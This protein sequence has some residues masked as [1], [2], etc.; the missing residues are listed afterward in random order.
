MCLCVC[1]CV[2]VCVGERER[3]MSDTFCII[4]VTMPPWELHPRKYTKERRFS[5]TMKRQNMLSDLS[6]IKND[7]TINK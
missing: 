5:G 6:C 3:D 4:I 7:F 1:V 2:C